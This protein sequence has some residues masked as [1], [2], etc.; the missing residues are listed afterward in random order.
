MC[1]KPNKTTGSIVSILAGTADS[2][3]GCCR[4]SP[5]GKAAR[6]GQAFL[7]ARFQPQYN[8]VAALFAEVAD[9]YDEFLGDETK[10]KWE[11]KRRAEQERAFWG[12]AVA[13]IG[14]AF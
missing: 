6:S 9:Q 12:A 4:Q 3:A 5:P 14:S 2:S 11:W 7:W 10:R 8:I 13:F 1:H